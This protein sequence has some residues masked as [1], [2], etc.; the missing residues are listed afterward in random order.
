MH[1][2]FRLY[3]QITNCID[4]RDGRSYNKEFIIH[5]DKD[6][7]YED[8]MKKIKDAITNPMHVNVIPIR[9]S[10]GGERQQ[11]IYNSGDPLSVNVCLNKKIILMESPDVSR[12]V[13]PIIASDYPNHD[14]DI[15]YLTKVINNMDPK[16]KITSD[17]FHQIFETKSR[18]KYR[19][20]IHHQNHTNNDDIQKEYQILL[21]NEDIEPNLVDT[22]EQS[23]DK[24]PYMIIKHR[25]HYIEYLLN[26]LERSINEMMSCGYLPHG[27]FAKYDMENGEK[28]VTQAMMITNHE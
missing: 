2:R 11:I 27:T 15:D 12:Y 14:Y 7:S 16:Y 23:N 17:N 28:M 10:R 20:Y 9:T 4:G 26:E 3:E 1:F 21:I 18:S 22:K 8:F 13:Y 19:Q 24:R 5:H 6:I 25:G